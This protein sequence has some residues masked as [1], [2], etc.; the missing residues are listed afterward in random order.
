MGLQLHI[1]RCVHRRRLFRLLVIRCCNRHCPPCREEE[2]REVHN[3]V[4]P[5][6]WTL[7][8]TGA[9]IPKEQHNFCPRSLSV[10]LGVSVCRCVYVTAYHLCLDGN[11]KIPKAMK[12]L[13][14]TLLTV[15]TSAP[16]LSVTIRSIRNKGRKPLKGSRKV[17]AG[18]TPAKVGYLLLL[19]AKRKQL[20][21]DKKKLQTVED[22]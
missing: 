22:F 14:A 20:L 13:T 3:S 11:I 2:H 5:S 7:D 18:A 10:S 21:K 1:H 16:A 8:D 19:S 15:V 17:N 4:A 9:R 12:A 6:V